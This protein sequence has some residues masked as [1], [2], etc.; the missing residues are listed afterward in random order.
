MLTLAFAAIAATAQPQTDSLTVT[1]H[2]CINRGLKNNYEIQIVRLDEQVAENNATLANAG[3]LPAVNATAGYTG[4]LSSTETKQGGTTNRNTNQLAHTM[5]AQVAADWT[6]FDGFKIQTNYKRLKE[7]RRKSEVQ[8]RVAIED[9]VAESATAYFNVVRQ[10]LRMK[11]LRESLEL[12]RER[13][14]IVSERYKLGSASRLDLRSA[15]VD[16]N[17]DSAQVLSQH[18]ALITSYVDLQELMGAA[19]Q[20][21]DGF[22][23]YIINPTDTAINLIKTISVDTLEQAMLRSNARLIAAASS[24]RLSEL[25]YKAVQS[26]DYPYVKLAANYGYTYNNQPQTPSMQRHEWGGQLGVTVGMKIF[27][28]QRKRERQNALIAIE[29]AQLAT[30]DLELTLRAQLERLWK[31]YINNYQLLGLAQENLRAAEEQ[32]EA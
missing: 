11:N 7:L 29:Q 17:A 1:L 30:A 32:Y 19:A 24:E 4:N 9:F 2:Q 5:R 31:S 3:A 8:T 23:F 22:G 27:D 13:L 18:E 16:F 26:R 21:K 6:L 28:G 25:D 20:Y 10:R 14:R 12:S 15:E